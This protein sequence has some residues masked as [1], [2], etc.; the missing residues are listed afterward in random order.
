MKLALVQKRVPVW[1]I[2]VDKTEQQLE[3]IEQFSLG[4]LSV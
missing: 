2:M 3:K 4:R 1:I